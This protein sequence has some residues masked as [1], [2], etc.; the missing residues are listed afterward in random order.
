MRA[1][2]IGS[3]AEVS[4]LCSTQANGWNHDNLACAIRRTLRLACRTRAFVTAEQRMNIQTLGLTAS[5]RPV[6][7][8]ICRPDRAMHTETVW[9]LDSSLRLHRRQCAVLT[10]LGRGVAR[11][12]MQ[13]VPAQELA[14]RDAMAVLQAAT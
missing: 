6:A 12:G 7:A 3:A 1:S 5:Y 4:P 8:R 2:N 11:V 9:I 14:S 13:D 10:K